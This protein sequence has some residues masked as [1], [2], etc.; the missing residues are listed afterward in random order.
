MTTTKIAVD[1]LD[2]ALLKYNQSDNIKYCQ[3]VGC[4]IL[5]DL[6]IP[7]I[8]KQFIISKGLCSYLL[9]S[10]NVTTTMNCTSEC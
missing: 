1:K 8:I 6:S 7:L 4:N 5:S 9:N 2:E 3:W 10:T